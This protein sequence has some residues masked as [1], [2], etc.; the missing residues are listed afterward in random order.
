MRALKNHGGVK[1]ADLG[2]ENIKALAAGFEN[3]K[4]QIENVGSVRKH[5]CWL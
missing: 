4:K 3:L 1:K 5:C 2:L